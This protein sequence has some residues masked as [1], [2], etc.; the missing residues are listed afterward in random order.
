VPTCKVGE[1]GSGSPSAFATLRHGL[2]VD[3]SFGGQA[4]AGAIA[5]RASEIELIDVLFIEYLWRPEK[6]LTPVNDLYLSKFPR[7]K[8]S[9]ARF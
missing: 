2:T 9:R 3:C 5:R 1:V 7:L 8:L 4:V 6:D